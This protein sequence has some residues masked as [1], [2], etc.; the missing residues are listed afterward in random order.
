MTFFVFN[1]FINLF[2]RT[3]T[4]GVL[5]V[6]TFGV[7]IHLDITPRLDRSHQSFPK[8]VG[9][10]KSLD[11][12]LS[13]S[14]RVLDRIRLWDPESTSLRG[15]L[16]FRSIDVRSPGSPTPRP[17]IRHMFRNGYSLTLRCLSQIFCILGNSLY[18]A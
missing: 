2:I 12:P 1:S 14:G 4:Y 6:L 17:K 8:E 11:F 18:G 7:K 9:Y 13:F 16:P 10:N 15:R 5:T 3:L